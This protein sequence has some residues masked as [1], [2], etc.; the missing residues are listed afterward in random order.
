MQNSDCKD[1]PR[2]LVAPA[3]QGPADISCMEKWYVH[4]YTPLGKKVGISI[5][6]MLE[7]SRYAIFMEEKAPAGCSELA[8]GL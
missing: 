7:I 2:S 3:K 1:I 6:P 5:M 8:R 4:K